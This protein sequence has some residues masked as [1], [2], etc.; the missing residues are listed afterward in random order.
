VSAIEQTRRGL[1]LRGWKYSGES[2]C[3]ACGALIL[4][5]DTTKW[6]PAKH[7]F[8]KM[9]MSVIAGSED[10][11]DRLIEPHWGVCP[12]RDKFRSEPKGKRK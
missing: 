11:E 12:E 8:K 5:F 10:A 1:E 6:D 4:W 2:Q 3:K 9:P 7:S